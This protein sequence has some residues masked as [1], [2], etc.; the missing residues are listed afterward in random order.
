LSLNEFFSAIN[1]KPLDIAIERR[2]VFK[3]S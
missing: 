3:T 2:K 1:K